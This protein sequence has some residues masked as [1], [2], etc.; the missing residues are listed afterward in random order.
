MV[1]R[2]RKLENV[3]HD[4]VVHRS[5]ADVARVLRDCDAKRVLLIADR[6]AWEATGAEVLLADAWADRAVVRFD[7]LAPLMQR[8]LAVTLDPDLEHEEIFDEMSPQATADEFLD[9]WKNP[10]PESTCHGPR[11]RRRKR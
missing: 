1:K 2:S 4:Q 7:V 9:R 6:G 11:H 8:R 10:R 3:Q 5:V